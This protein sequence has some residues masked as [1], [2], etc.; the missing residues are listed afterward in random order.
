MFIEKNTNESLIINY[1]DTLRQ[2]RYLDIKYLLYFAGVENND[3]S[4][5]E[6]GSKEEALYLQI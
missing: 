5:Y 1:F 3:K 6:K 4:K 2:L